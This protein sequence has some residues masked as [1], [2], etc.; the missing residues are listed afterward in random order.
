[1]DLPLLSIN[2]SIFIAKM[3]IGS[4]LRLL[5]FLLKR[6]LKKG[7]T[8]IYPEIKRLEV[9]LI[10]NKNIIKLEDNMEYTKKAVGTVVIFYIK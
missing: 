2:E 3:P 9:K 6:N 5:V 1:M 7:L 4:P 8:V 10:F